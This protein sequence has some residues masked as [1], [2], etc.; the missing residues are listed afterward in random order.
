MK[1]TRLLI[2]LLA[3]LC[4]LLS[5]CEG[6]TGQSCPMNPRG[7]LSWPI[8]PVRE[9]TVLEPFR[10]CV[11]APVYLAGTLGYYEDEGL[12]VTFRPM[13]ETD[14]GEDVLILTD[15]VS[16]METDGLRIVLTTTRPGSFPLP[17]ELPESE[18]AAGPERDREAVFVVAAPSGFL[19]RDPEMVQKASNAFARAMEWMG[20]AEPEELA[21]TLAPLFPG[22]EEALLA[23]AR[24]DRQHGLFSAT[25]RHTGKGYRQAAEAARAA[26]AA[27]EI[28]GE[29]A[30]YEESFLDRARDLLNA[31]QLCRK[32]GAA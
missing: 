16:A 7:G 6:A 15:L 19:Q 11:W 30:L 5:A 10:G 18:A 32:H 28:P 23:A 20:E 26:G 31:S 1:G 2:P 17:R 22:E 21:Q 13:G 4:V 9:L 24:Y 3:G 14:P 12:E 8:E 27:G 25:G 29:R